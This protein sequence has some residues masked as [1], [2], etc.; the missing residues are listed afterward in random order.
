MFLN[1]LN[2]LWNAV[3]VKFGRNWNIFDSLNQNSLRFKFVVALTHTG[4][5]ICAENHNAV[6]LSVVVE[7]RSINGK[8]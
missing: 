5:I 8:T 4:N 6:V 3:K 2:N 7:I 1:G